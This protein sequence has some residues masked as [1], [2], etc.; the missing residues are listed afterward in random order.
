MKATGLV[1][2]P[3]IISAPPTT[4]RTAPIHIWENI[5]GVPPPGISIGH[6]KSFTVPACM[7]MTAATI[8]STLSSCGAHAD[9]FVPILD[10]DMTISF[11]VH[12]RS[13]QRPFDKHLER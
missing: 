13:H 6:P 8:R 11:L 2:R 12:C 9:H 3:T 4:S 7:N 5:G 10:A 1:K